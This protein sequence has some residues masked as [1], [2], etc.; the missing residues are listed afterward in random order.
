MVTESGEA[1]GFVQL[2]WSGLY[3][4]VWGRVENQTGRFDLRW[5]V[6]LVDSRHQLLPGTEYELTGRGG[7]GNML[8]E[9]PLR[10]I[11]VAACAVIESYPEFCTSEAF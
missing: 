11:H 3:R 8:Y 2:R 5:R 6:F 7:Y 4:T 1:I 10:P 9:P